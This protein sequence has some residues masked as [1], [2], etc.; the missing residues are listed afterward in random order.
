MRPANAQVTH[1]NYHERSVAEKYTAYYT[2]FHL[3]KNCNY[4]VKIELSTVHAMGLPL[5]GLQI[6]D[7]VKSLVAFVA[8]VTRLHVCAKVCHS[9]V[10]TAAHVELAPELWSVVF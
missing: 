10:Y 1:G 6:P 5:V 9:G 8:V 7:E 3:G 4:F 2:T